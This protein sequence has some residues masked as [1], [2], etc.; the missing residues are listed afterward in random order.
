MAGLVAGKRLLIA[1]V[2]TEASIAYAVARLAQQE[3]ARIVLTGYGRLS[4][5]ERVARKLPEPPPVIELDVTDQ[6]QLA[7]LA[8]QVRPHLSGLDGV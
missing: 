6:A 4:L 7:A 8:E 1:G 5:V 3:G 2:I